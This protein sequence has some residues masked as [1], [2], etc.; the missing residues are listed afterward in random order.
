MAPDSGGLRGAQCA[1]LI[2]MRPDTRRFKLLASSASVAT[3]V[4]LLG[5]AAGSSGEA[6]IAGT[7]ASLALFTAFAGLAWRRSASATKALLSW[8]Q[9]G[10]GL[11][12]ELRRARRRRR[13]QELL[14]GTGATG[15]TPEEP[16]N[17]KT[18]A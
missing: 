7:V 11:E 16:V 8:E 15:Q 2:S 14:R 3:A 4:A 6:A 13:M 10:L 5:F 18:N 9:V 1:Q 17:D 12:R